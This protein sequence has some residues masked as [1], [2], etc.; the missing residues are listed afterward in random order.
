[1]FE[2]QR[3]FYV[4]LIRVLIARAHQCALSRNRLLFFFS[5]VGSLQLISIPFF[6]MMVAV[7]I[8]VYV[9]LSVCVSLVCTVQ[10]KSCA[11]FPMKLYKLLIARF[12]ILNWFSNFHTHSLLHLL[13]SIYIAFSFSVFWCCCC[14]SVFVYFANFQFRLAHTHT[15][16]YSKR[17]TIKH[18]LIYIYTYINMSSWPRFLPNK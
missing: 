7:C 6:P 2:H 5:S 1:M 15:H 10:K 17:K 4:A 16:S 12:W 18:T 13:S 11:I 9:C 8:V 14:F 3:E